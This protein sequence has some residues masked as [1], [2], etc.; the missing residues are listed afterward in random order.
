M[1]LS[2]GLGSLSYANQIAIMQTK[3]LSR[4]AF[5]L[6]ALGV[7]ILVGLAECVALLRAR[8]FTGRGQVTGA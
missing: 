7:A 6:F 2:S 1:P 3:K 4:H 5:Q 8:C